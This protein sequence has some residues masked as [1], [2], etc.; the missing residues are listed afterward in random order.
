LTNEIFIRLK[1]FQKEKNVAFLKKYSLTDQ[2]R[3]YI[4]GEYWTLAP[5]NY[6][7]GIVDLINNINSDQ[8]I[9]SVTPTLYPIFKFRTNNSTKN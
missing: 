5:L 2:K 4:L 8:E 6:H 9:K 3:E 7:I 1:V